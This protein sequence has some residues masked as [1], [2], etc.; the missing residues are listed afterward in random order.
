ME[1]PLSSVIERIMVGELPEKEIVSKKKTEKI[2][3]EMYTIQKR[4]ADSL[5]ASAEPK[6]GKREGRC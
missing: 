3:K 1:C 2:K 5:Q 6:G 4:S